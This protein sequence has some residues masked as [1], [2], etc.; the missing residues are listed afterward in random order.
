MRAILPALAIAAAV[1]FGPGAAGAADLG[2]YEDDTYIER[3]ARVIER[4]RVVVERRY[5]P[6]AR[7][8]YDD[9]PEVVYVP[10]RRVYSYHAG[11]PYYG[12]R[13]FHHRHDRWHKH[14]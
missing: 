9:E 10:R 14:W 8:Y 2:G 6:E 12:P 3:P 7:V 4:E 11:Y 1:S 5:Y 13:R